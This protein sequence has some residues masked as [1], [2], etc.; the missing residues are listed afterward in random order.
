MKKKGFTL[1]EL[2]AVI[3]ILAIIA[4]IVTPVVSNIILSA[5]KAAN[6]RSVEGHIKNIEYAIIEKAFEQGNGDLTIFDSYTNDSD[7]K[8]ELTLPDSDKILCVSLTIED[9]IVISASGCKENDW[10]SDNVFNYTLGVG[11]Y[12]FDVIDSCPGCVYAFPSDIWYYTG[13]NPT[14]IDSSSY[15]YIV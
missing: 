1:I 12:A 7:L 8:N 4:L 2:L 15:I 14:V 3:V 6:A 13:S 10:P 5:R 9:G 11:A